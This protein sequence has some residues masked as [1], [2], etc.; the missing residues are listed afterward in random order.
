MFWKEMT[1]PLA[2]AQIP[3]VHSATTMICIMVT[4]S[5]RFPWKKGMSSKSLSIR[6]TP[7]RTFPYGHKSARLCGERP[8]VDRNQFAYACL[9]HSDAVNN[10]HAAHGHFVV[11]H[12]DELGI[13]AELADHIGKLAH[14][15]IVQRG[16]HLIQN[17]KRCRLDQV[18]GEKQGGCRERFFP[19]AQ[20]RNGGRSFPF[21]FG[22]DIDA[23]LSQVFRIVQY[24]I[25][26]V[27]FCK[28]G[29]EH[30][31][32]ILPHLSEGIEELLVCRSFHFLYGL[33]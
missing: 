13:I 21:G 16:V 28:Q 2:T 4:S 27:F 30:F 5:G 33:Q 29:L 17:T 11:G 8:K 19:A 14:V 10:I 15:G 26:G 25:R 24:E 9:L 23:G 3:M 1:E 12:D 22:Y 6:P 7:A 18:D 32:E 31:L 20:L